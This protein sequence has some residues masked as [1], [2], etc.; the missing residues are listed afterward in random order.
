MQELGISRN[1]SETLLELHSALYLCVIAVLKLRLKQPGHAAYDLVG[2][3]PLEL[4]FRHLRKFA[5]ARDDCFQVVYFCQQCR[6]ALAKNF[7]EDLRIL[8]S[9]ADQV[10]DC[11]L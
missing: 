1:R 4:W 11:E 3:D 5:E 9:R 2:I 7:V 10:F 6:R 8:F